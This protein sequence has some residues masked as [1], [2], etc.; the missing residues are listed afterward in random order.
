MLLNQ[1]KRAGGRPGAMA[2]GAVLLLSGAVAEA[3]NIRWYCDPLSVNLTSANVPL[4]G[5]FRFELGAFA[6]GFVPTGTN[7]QN[8]AA[9]WVRA[10]RSLYNAT[11][12][13]FT[14]DYALSANTA[15]FTTGAK[16]YIW[17]FG[18][19]N[20]DEWILIS[21]STWTWPQ[22]DPLN[23]V[24]IN[25]NASQSTAVVGTVGSGSPFLLKTAAVAASS[26]PTTT[27]AQ[28]RTEM[29]D[30]V[31]LN[32]AQDDPDGD[33]IVNALEFL[34]GGDPRAADRG[35]PPAISYIQSG[36]QNFLQGTFPRRLDR[37]ASVVIELSEN[38]STWSSSAGVLE[39]SSSTQSSV[40]V[41]SLLPVNQTHPRQFLRLRW[42]VSP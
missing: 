26:P 6:N 19:R 24:G 3:R 38:L 12:R 2:A 41:R 40:V 30:G 22:A 15:P 25:W 14:G 20:G 23:P 33:G 1:W 8:W 10:Q 18:G 37:P 13:L 34:Q 5:D 36:G 21:A 28:W 31:A 16:A 42:T 39:T 17:G 35:V 29:L 27:W 4:N 11:N 9:N 7:T 32:G